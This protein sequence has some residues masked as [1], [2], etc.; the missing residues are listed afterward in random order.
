MPSSH[1]PEEQVQ[2]VQVWRSGRLED[3]V[4]SREVH[5]FFIPRL[6]SGTGMRGSGVHDASKCQWTRIREITCC[7]VTLS[8]VK[9]NQRPVTHVDNAADQYVWVVLIHLAEHG[10]VDLL[11]NGG[12]ILPKALCRSTRAR[13]AAPT[14]SS[15]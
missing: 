12:E 13:S 6:G 7:V 4:P 5:V 15:I 2:K 9:R 3:D 14:F 10:S 1:Q 8:N 11:V